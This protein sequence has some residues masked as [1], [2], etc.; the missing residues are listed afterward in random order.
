[1]KVKVINKTKLWINGREYIF[2]AGI[3]DVD[4]DKA[5]ILT[6]SGYAEKIIEELPEDKETKR[7]KAK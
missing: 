7:K 3:H 1:M 6:A 2:E 5:R 4:E